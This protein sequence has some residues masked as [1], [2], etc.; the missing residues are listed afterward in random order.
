MKQMITFSIPRKAWI[1][2]GW[3]DHHPR[4]FQSCPEMAVAVRE[5]RRIG[6]GFRW[7]VT[8]HRVVAWEMLRWLERDLDD[9]RIGPAKDTLPEGRSVRRA[10]RNIRRAL[11]HG[12]TR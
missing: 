9:L 1:Q 11:E 10:I 8:T 3:E 2:T 6:D 4:R 12:A 7:Q 5:A